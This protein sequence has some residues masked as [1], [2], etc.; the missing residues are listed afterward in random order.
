MGLTSGRKLAMALLVGT[1]SIGVF[2]ALRQEPSSDRI[3]TTEGPAAQPSASV[4]DSVSEDYDITDTDGDGLPDRIELR[5]GSSITAVDT[6]GD[7][8]SDAIEW[9]GLGILSLTDPDSDHNGIGDAEDDADEDGIANRDEATLKGNI[10]SADG[11]SDG[12]SDFEESEQGSSG[13]VSDTDQDGVEDGLEKLFGLSP[14]KPDSDN[15]GISDSEEMVDHRVTSERG[16]GVVRALANDDVFV[17]EVEAGSPGQRSRPMNVSVNQG[18]SEN[19]GTFSV[20]L[21]GAADDLRA[22]V[23]DETETVPFWLPTDAEV[24][25]KDGWATFTVE[26]PVS[27]VTVGSLREYNLFW[28]KK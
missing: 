24:V 2:F 20:P 14:S 11:D 25:V 19:G 27:M 13:L 10:L 28:G 3:I 23:Y 17:G 15:D 21:T 7:G 16:T 1:I 9:E 6:D 18:S 22:F 4:S 5:I 12:L 8:L 26:Q